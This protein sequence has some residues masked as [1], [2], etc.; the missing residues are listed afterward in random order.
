MLP[1]YVKACS[2][3]CQQPTSASLHRNHDLCHERSCHLLPAGEFMPFHA[4]IGKQHFSWCVEAI[5]FC[6]WQSFGR[7][8]L[9][10]NLQ[11]PPLP[12]FRPLCALIVKIRVL[13]LT[14]LSCTLLFERS[15]LLALVGRSR[16]EPRKPSGKE[17]HDFHCFAIP[18]AALHNLSLHYAVG[19]YHHTVLRFAPYGP[20][21]EML[22]QACACAH[23]VH[24]S[25]CLSWVVC[26]PRTAA[27]YRPYGSR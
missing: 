21:G 8:D 18:Q 26:I 10:S 11:R 19:P 25:F 5:A 3:S 6:K 15:C 16:R 20:T 17:T 12:N 9:A 2:T 7:P 13:H 23:F 24:Q 27:S 1:S 4:S 14:E 22:I